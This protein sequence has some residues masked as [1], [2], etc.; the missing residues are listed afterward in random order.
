MV[1]CSF[2]SPLPYSSFK[3][4]RVPEQLFSHVTHGYTY[5]H[6]DTHLIDPLAVNYYDLRGGGHLYNHFSMEDELRTVRFSA[7]LET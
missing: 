4:S 3:L 5:M 2:V 7:G 6:A 1:D